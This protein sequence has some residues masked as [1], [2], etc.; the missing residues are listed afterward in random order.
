[1]TSRL[2]W[3]RPSSKSLPFYRTAFRFPIMLVTVTLAD[4]FALARGQLVIRVMQVVVGKRAPGAEN[5]IEVD[6]ERHAVIA[7]ELGM[8]QVVVPAAWSLAR[9]CIARRAGG[10]YSL[11]PPGAE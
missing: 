8:V 4:W 10:C 6:G 9:G 7:L 1:V 5:R 3:H 11:S 2:R